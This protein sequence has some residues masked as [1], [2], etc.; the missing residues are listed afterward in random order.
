[1]NFKKSLLVVP[2]SMSLLIPTAGLAN[3]QSSQ[4]GKPTVST[5]ASELRSTLDKDLSEHAFLAV[6]A[7]RRG[8]EGAKDFQA[9]VN[10]LKNNT[11]DLTK[12]IASVYGKDAGD[13][14][15][16]MWSAHIGYFVDYVK[17]TGA[18]DEGAKKKAL[19]ELDDYSKDFAAFLSKATG[20][21]VVA[22][23]ATKG[24]QSHIHDLIGAFDAYVAGD[25]DKAYNM[26]RD[27]IHHM[28][29]VS[30]SL[31]S[32]IT[33][34]MPDKFDN[35]KAVTPAA[36]LRSNLNY[37]LAEHAGLATQAMQ[38]GIDGAKDFQAS[39][40]ALAEN[41]DDLSKAIASV[42]GDEAGKK[43]KEMWSAHIGNFVDYV[44]A[45]GAKDENKKQAAKDA[46]NEYSKNFANFIATATDGNTPSDA[47][48]KGLQEHISQLIT[49]FDDY[50]AKDYDKAWDKIDMAYDHMFMSSKGIA[51][52][53]VMQNPDKF[54][55]KGMPSDM[56]KTGLGGSQQTDYFE[57]FLLAL[58]A[59]AAGTA[60]YATQRGSKQQ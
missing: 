13:A 30:K 52:G 32:A 8:A 5:P 27:A 21:K 40:Q 12:D 54:M 14:F 3:A 53:I 4:T 46:L 58:V 24:L 39:A 51:G 59:L 41:T 23:D 42:Y 17:A 29:M 19:S 10:E 28:Y 26:E 45:T 47:V 16:K 44:K 57:W 50:A 36:D 11:D 22:S 35:T 37:L 9:A 25:Y 56:P 34:Q 49:A 20:G 55:M 2:M 6:E 60:F 38:N 43:F 48:Q 18:K 7:M 31:S 1:M 15:K 33:S